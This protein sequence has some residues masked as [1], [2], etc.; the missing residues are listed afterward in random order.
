MVVEAGRATRAL[1]AIGRFPAIYVAGHL[2]PA[3]GGRQTDSRCPCRPRRYAN[4]GRSAKVPGGQARL[5]H[6]VQHRPDAGADKLGYA[7]ALARRRPAG[8]CRCRSAAGGHPPPRTMALAACRGTA[9]AA[10][11]RVD[12]VVVLQ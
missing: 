5:E 3:L 11:G 7:V 9:P 6:A 12:L 8:A 10:P 1:W 2:P 4:R